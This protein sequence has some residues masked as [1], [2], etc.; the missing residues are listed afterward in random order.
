MKIIGDGKVSQVGGNIFITYFGPKNPDNT[1]PTKTIVLVGDKNLAKS[2]ENKSF[3][4]IR[5]ELD[6]VINFTRSDGAN[7]TLDAD[8]KLDPPTQAYTPDP[9]YDDI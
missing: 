9:E 5:N 8:G 1:V 6:D 3:N 2:W 4:A 7:P